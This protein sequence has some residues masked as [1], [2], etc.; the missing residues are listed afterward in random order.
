MN[1]RNVVSESLDHGG[2]GKDPEQWLAE[3]TE[4]GG[5]WFDRR[6]TG[7]PRTD[8]R[9]TGTRRDDDT[10]GPSNDSCSEAEPFEALSEDRR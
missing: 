4:I 8:T 2:N 5:R 3:E 1:A 6:A 9:G 7:E 10:D